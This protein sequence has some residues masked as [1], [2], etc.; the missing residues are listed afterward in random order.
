MKDNKNS[1]TEVHRNNTQNESEIFYIK[2][3]NSN[4]EANLEY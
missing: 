3:Y 4:S 1:K 2:K